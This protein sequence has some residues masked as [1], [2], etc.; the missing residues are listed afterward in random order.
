MTPQSRIDGPA[1]AV[2]DQAFAAWRW[3][4]G[5]A[6]RRR[7][8]GT[9]RRR[10]TRG[11]GHR[12]RAGPGARLPGHRAA[13]CRQPASGSGSPTPTWSRRRG[14]SR[15]CATRRATG[16]TC[17]CWCRGPAT[18]RWCGTCPRIGYRELL[19]TGVRIYEWDGPMLHAKTIVCDGRWVRVGSSNLNLSSLLGNYELDVLIEDPALAQSMERQFRLD[20]ARSR[21]V[22][23]RRLR[24]PR[25]ISEA[26][27]TALTTEHPE[28]T[29][30]PLSPPPARA[31]RRAVLALADPREQR[32]PVGLPPDGGCSSSPSA[33]CSSHCRA[34]R[35]TSSARSAPGWRSG[36]GGGV[37]PEGGSVGRPGGRAVGRSGGRAVEADRGYPVIPS[38]A[39]DPT[40][41]SSKSRVRDPLVASASSGRHSST[42]PTARPPDR[43][44]STPTR[45][46]SGAAIPGARK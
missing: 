38:E 27:P 42:P 2:L 12:R 46:S 21:E 40:R 39:R 13:G 22:R 4:E 45:I 35:R 5:A 8:G 30:V 28:V 33:C 16:S 37:S 6:A 41:W 3:P 20:I 24:G 15:R 9:S 19:R 29:P 14:S 7:A 43:R 18:S 17:G 26:L 36:P 44:R 25:R 11:P 34:R 23:R 10:E 1:A 32:A 31:R